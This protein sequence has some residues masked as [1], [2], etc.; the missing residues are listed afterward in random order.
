MG[1]TLINGKITV[2]VATAG[3]AV[4]L[5][6]FFKLVHN[7][8]KKNNALEGIMGERKKKKARYFLV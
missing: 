3:V 8:K 2:T 5:V 4:L 6:Y 1:V 7:K